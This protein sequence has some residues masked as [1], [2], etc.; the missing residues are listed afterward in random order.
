MTLED[1]RRGLAE[2]FHSDIGIQWFVS[3]VPYK[4]LD[5]ASVTRANM[6]EIQ[7][8]MMQEK[9]E[10]EEEEEEEEPKRQEEEEKEVLECSFYLTLLILTFS[11]K[12]QQP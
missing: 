1:L 5:V 4:E 11:R 8:Q 7:Q 6:D 12:K 2:Y 9:E 10:E 3:H